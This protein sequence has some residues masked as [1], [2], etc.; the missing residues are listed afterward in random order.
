[1]NVNTRILAA[2]AGC[3][4]MLSPAAVAADE[5]A[6]TDGNRDRI[7]RTG[8]TVLGGWAT[9]NIGAGLAGMALSED[10]T[11]R[12][13]WEM[14]A[15]WNTVNLGLAGWSLYD[16]WRSSSAGAASEAEVTDIE[17]YREESHSFEKVLLFNAGLNFA[18]MAV[19][20]WMW[21]RGS[22]GEGLDA[23]GISADRLTGWGQSLV[24]QGAFLLGFDLTMWRAIARDR[25]VTVNG[26][27]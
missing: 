16:Q 27:D 5:R 25:A 20:G 7:V 23:G 6:A 24:A 2:V 4:L 13:F 21:D 18:Y 1:M 8:M 26:A 17:T 19:G 12:G 14:N 9:A 11:Q 3:L 22:R 10:S 15:M